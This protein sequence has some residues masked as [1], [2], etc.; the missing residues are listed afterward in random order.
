MLQGLSFL[1]KKYLCINASALLLKE[2]SAQQVISYMFIKTWLRKT[3]D[4]FAK[5]PIGGVTR[6]CIVEF[7]VT[8][9]I[10]YNY[11]LHVQ[12]ESKNCTVIVP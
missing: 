12:Y 9:V 6:M 2:Y 5:E 4:I 10:D 11:M 1:A 7:V 3:V 8:C